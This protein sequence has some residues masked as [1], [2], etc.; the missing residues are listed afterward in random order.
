M[1]DRIERLKDWLWEITKILSL[2]VAVS[3]LVAVLFGPDA[4]FFGAVLGNLEPVI[5]SLGSEG[6]G[7]I[8]ALIIII[9]VW[10]GRS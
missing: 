3:L 5:N 9:A 10:R 4:P 2:V 7:L 1:L 8:I 6:L